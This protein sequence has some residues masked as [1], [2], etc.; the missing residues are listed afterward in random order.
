VGAFPVHGLTGTISGILPGIFAAGFITQPGHA[1]INI[2]GQI[3]G[4]V[5]YGIFLGFIP[6]RLFS[7]LLKKFNLLHVSAETEEAGLDLSELGGE[8]CPEK[9]SIYAHTL[10]AK[11]PT[12][13]SSPAVQTS[14]DKGPAYGMPV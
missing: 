8:A 13:T 5:I 14:T 3:G 1:P 9:S 11:I 4:V 2:F 7:L 6:G 12:A 10:P